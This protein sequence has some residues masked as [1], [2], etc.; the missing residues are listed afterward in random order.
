MET[1][2]DSLPYLIVST[3]IIL[4]FTTSAYGACYGVTLSATSSSLF[5]QKKNILTYAYLAVIMATSIYFFAVIL[6]VVILS[7]ITEAYKL[8]HSVRH[9]SACCLTGLIGYTV[10]ITMG[11]I[12]KNGFPVLYKEKILVL[13]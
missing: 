7:N 8:E 3:G 6:F 9:F 11:N 1:F 2:L 4:L 13:Y 5:T 12:S 10:G